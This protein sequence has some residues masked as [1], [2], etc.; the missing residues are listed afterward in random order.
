MHRSCSIQL[1]FVQLQEVE[2]CWAFDLLLASKS[3]LSKYSMALVEFFR[4]LHSDEELG[5]IVVGLVIGVGE[6]SSMGESEALMK[7][8][9]KSSSP[10]T[11]TAY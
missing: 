10:Y 9:L 7:L 8:L 2:Y 5:S 3:Y 11:F 6:D 1:H 4:C